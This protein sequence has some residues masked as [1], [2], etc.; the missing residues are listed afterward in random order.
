MLYDYFGNKE[1]LFLAVLEQSYRDIRDAERA[2]NLSQTDPVEGIR[3]L[4]AFTWNSY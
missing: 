2:L 3:S 1:D 4:I